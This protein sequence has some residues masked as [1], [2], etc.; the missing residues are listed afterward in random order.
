MAS[1]CLKR[2]LDGHPT[3]KVVPAELDDHQAGA[4]R[5]DVP[6]HP[7]QTRPHRVP[8]HAGVDERN[9]ERLGDQRR[10]AL[11]GPDAVTLGDAVTEEDDQVA[12]RREVCDPP[13]VRPGPGPGQPQRRP[14]PGASCSRPQPT[15]SAAPTAPADRLRR[16]APA[17]PQAL[18][19][20]DGFTILPDPPRATARSRPWH[21]PAGRPALPTCRRARPTCSSSSFRSRATSRARSPSL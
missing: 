6:L 2:L 21:A 18:R 17:I 15:T 4:V 14:Q 7:G 12:R 11:L 5:Q 16:A 19:A 10:K 1:R 8:G 3:E 9:A 20:P 13:D